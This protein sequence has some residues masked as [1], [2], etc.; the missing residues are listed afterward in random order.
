MKVILLDQGQL[1]CAPAHLPSFSNSRWRLRQDIGES[2]NKFDKKRSKNKDS[3]ELGLELGSLYNKKRV[4]S[5][6]SMVMTNF[7]YYGYLLSS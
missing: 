3:L 5:M 6:D 1:Q 2:H 4:V 7:L